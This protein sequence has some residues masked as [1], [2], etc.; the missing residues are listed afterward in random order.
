MSK[1]QNG[2]FLALCVLTALAMI[3]S[4]TAS[5]AANIT[6][7]CEIFR[8]A[9]LIDLFN[10][11]SSFISL[12]TAPSSA[13]D[14]GCDLITYVS[15]FT[16]S[17]AYMLEPQAL[18]WLGP[19]SLVFYGTTDEAAKLANMVLSSPVLSKRA[20][21]AYHHVLIRTGPDLFPA[22][23]LRNI[24]IQHVRTQYAITVDIDF[25]PRSNTCK[26][27]QKF[28]LLKSTRGG[29]AHPLEKFAYVL[30]SFEEY[31]Q[32]R[33]EFLRQF[34]DDKAALVNLWKHTGKLST[35]DAGQ[36]KIQA[37]TDFRR[38]IGATKP[39]EIRNQDMFEPIYL[40]SL[41]ALAAAV[42]D[43]SAELPPRFVVETMYFTALPG[44]LDIRHFSA[45]T[46]TLLSFKM[47][48]LPD[49][50]MVHVRHDGWPS[51]VN[52]Y[53]YCRSA[54][55]AKR[56]RHIRVLCEAQKKTNPSDYANDVFCVKGYIS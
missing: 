43:I 38:W 55:W 30:P 24:A 41:S 34:P 50:Y 17:R 39:Y 5:N 35:F 13:T 46:L 20:N 36:P 3:L 22:N 11:S 52:K 16:M 1:L 4:P 47:V 10:V 19:M 21:I 12:A 23:I 18:H 51:D 37:P 54:S 29:V 44:R 15:L 33:T 25:L 32:D 45:M 49:E 56:N 48:V 26:R 7:T 14:D 40:Y 9:T 27:L 8:N 31:F 2:F 53:N 28:L 42:E 6:E